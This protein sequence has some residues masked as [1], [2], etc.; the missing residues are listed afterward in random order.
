RCYQDR[1]TDLSLLTDAL[2][3]RGPVV[4]L[5]HDGGG[6]ISAGWALDNRHDLPGTILTNTGMHPKVAASR[7][8]ARQL[9]NA[10]GLRTAAT[11]HTD[12]C[13]R[14][15]LALSKPA[16]PREVQDAYFGAYRGRARRRG[17]DQFVADIPAAADHTSRETL[18]RGAEG[19]KD[20]R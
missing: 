19:I 13:P 11:S 10:P 9:A 4:T 6:L 7:P 3:L 16:L 1:I 8:E 2:S 12:A 18:E 17:I 20:L 5:G 15:S 14:T